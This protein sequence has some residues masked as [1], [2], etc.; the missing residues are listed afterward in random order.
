MNQD[1]VAAAASTAA[2]LAS[3]LF[4]GVGCSNSTDQQGGGSPLP[5]IQIQSAIADGTTN[6]GQGPFA[7]SFYGA[8]RVLDAGTMAGL[9]A[10][11]QMNTWPEGAPIVVTPTLDPTSG[12][13]NATAQVSADL[14]LAERWYS[15]GFG[16]PQAGL[17]NH[18]TF[19]DGIWGVRLRPDSHPVVNIAEFCTATDPGTKF[20]VTFSESVTIDR[21]LEALTVQRNGVVLSC[22]LDDVRP[23]N[24]HQFCGDLTPG[25]VTVSL[26][27]GTV[28]GPDGAFLASQIWMVDIA[29]LPLV[30]AGCNGY[31]VPL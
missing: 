8:G 21:P 18:Q 12:T 25:P 3:V 5:V 2:F 14:P 7:V 27:A 31:R 16:P 6:A 28:R 20:I 4:G 29:K 30:E 1:K 23:N 22:R 19:D 13:T 17:A 9:L 10:R 24:V 26:A 15:L 11:L